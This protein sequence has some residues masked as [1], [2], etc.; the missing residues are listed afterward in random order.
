MI[1]P[2]FKMFY[3]ATA[4]FAVVLTTITLWQFN[5]LSALLPCALIVTVYILFYLYI[6]VS[7]KQNERWMC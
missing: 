6:I 5:P 2:K 4:L 7:T 3:W 1:T